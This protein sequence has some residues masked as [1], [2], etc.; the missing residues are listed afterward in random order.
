MENGS[1]LEPAQLVA[2]LLVEAVVGVEP[3]DPVSRGVLQAGVAGGGEVVDPG[4][5]EDLGPLVARNLALA[6]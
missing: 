5:V 4:E 6:L 3:E 1:I 2:V